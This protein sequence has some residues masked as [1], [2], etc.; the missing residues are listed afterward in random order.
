[1]TG[2]AATALV[3]LPVVVEAVRGL[4]SGRWDRQSAH[5]TLNQAPQ[6]VASGRPIEQ[7]AADFRRLRDAVASD[8]HRSAERQLADRMA[9][10]R[11]LV[12]LCDMIS[13]DHHLGA[14]VVG[15]E[16]DLER[17]RLEAE[18]ERAGINLTGPSS[19]P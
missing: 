15:R 16:R 2:A 10:D 5:G 9:Y 8:A 14:Q 11:V 7:L 19:R 3:L 18:I 12:E 17:F 4:V 13:I 1:M 6:P